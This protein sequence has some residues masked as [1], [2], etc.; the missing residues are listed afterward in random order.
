MDV[1]RNDAILKVGEKQK[2]SAK[3]CTPAISAV[4][5]D[6]LFVLFVCSLLLSQHQ[7]LF[8]SLTFF[9]SQDPDFSLDINLM[10]K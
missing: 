5:I 7:S 8:F 2:S 4:A 3:K 9:L 6:F 10:R 1:H